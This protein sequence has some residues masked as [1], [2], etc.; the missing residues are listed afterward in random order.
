M[1]CRIA[2]FGHWTCGSVLAA[3][4]LTRLALPLEGAD[5]VWGSSEPKKLAI[6]R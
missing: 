5:G 4:P 1:G 2:S 3:I 6:Y